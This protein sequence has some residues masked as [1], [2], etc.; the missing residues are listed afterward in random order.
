ME[1]T[2]IIERIRK[3]FALSRDQSTSI[4]EA[5]L[6]L[7]K[8]NEL[9]L[10]YNVTVEDIER[11]ERE[12]RYG[13]RVLFVKSKLQVYDKYILDILQTFFHIVILRNRT[14]N[15]HQ[16]QTQYQ[17]SH[18]T[19]KNI[20][21][22]EYRCIGSQVHLECALLVYHYLKTIFLR[23]YREYCRQYPTKHLQSQAFYLGMYTGLYTQL[24]TQVYTEEI[25][26]ALV[27][28]DQTIYKYILAR[29]GDLE[30]FDSFERI[31]V[32]DPLAF[33][34]GEQRGLQIN[35]HVLQQQ[36]QQKRLSE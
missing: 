8:A 22:Y 20:Y 34:K 14:M 6:A 5:E 36:G 18:P 1:Y 33:Q 12:E 29:Y 19:Q 23:E 31:F 4:H 15:I 21:V 10:K 30:T 16:S 2:A 3:L 7:V 11:S 32:R 26:Q 27:K 17:S 24:Q 35:V 13:E 25:T 9:L 28:Y